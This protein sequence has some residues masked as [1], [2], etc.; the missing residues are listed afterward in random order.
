M[1]S[2]FSSKETDCDGWYKASIDG[3]DKCYK[4]LGEFKM[5]EAASKCAEVNAKLPLPLNDNENSEIFA[6]KD[7]LKA[8]K[9]VLDGDDTLVE[10]EWRDSNGELLAYFN[11]NKNQ[12]NNSGKT[13]HYITIENIQISYINL[14]TKFKMLKK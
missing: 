14:K 6:L 7:V 13:Q 4:L 9:F 5:S 2:F 10:G 1:E 8:S 3:T 12:P 11:W